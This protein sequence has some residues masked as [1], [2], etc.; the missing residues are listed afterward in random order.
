MHEEEARIRELIAARP[1]RTSGMATSRAPI[2]VAR[3]GLWRRLGAADPLSRSGRR[4]VTRRQLDIAF[5][6]IRFPE[7]PN[8][9]AAELRSWEL[10]E[11]LWEYREAGGLTAML[12]AEINHQWRAERRMQAAA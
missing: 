4:D 1:F 6:P 9:L 5:N 10:E 11:L 2:A 7:V 8:F 12:C 3:C